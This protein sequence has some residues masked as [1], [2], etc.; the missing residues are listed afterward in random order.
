MTASHTDIIVAAHGWA[1]TQWQGDF[2]PDDLPEDWYLAYYSNEFRAVVVPATAWARTDAV[3]TERWMEDVADEFGFYLEVSDLLTDW[4]RFADV[5]KPLGGQVQGIIL[6]PEQL[7]PDLAMAAPSLEA[8]MALAPVTLLPPA[9]TVLSE[10]GAAL[11]QQLGVEQGWNVGQG[12]PNWR[13]GGLA[14]ARVAGNLNYTPRQWRETIEACLACPITPV[15][16]RRQVVLMVE[17]RPPEIEGLRAAMMIADM[18]VLP[19]GI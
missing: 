13:G 14:L 6:R 16:A 12:Q 8:A 7:D 11:L 3:E 19:E 2:Y 17:G 4:A 1:H 15:D 18:L 5:I 9:D 10:T